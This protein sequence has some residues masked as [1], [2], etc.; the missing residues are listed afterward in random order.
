MRWEYNDFPMI[1]HTSWQYK[2][3]VPLE[4]K[5]GQMLAVG[6]AAGADGI[7]SLAR[8][9]KASYAGNVILF[10]RNTPDVAE[11]RKTAASVKTLIREVTG[12]SPLIAIDQEGGIVSRLKGGLTPLPGAMAQAAAYLGGGIQKSDIK[13]LGKICAEELRSLG[14]NW[15]LAPVADV[16][17]NP[18]N[19][20]IG[21]RSY[22]E[23]PK[24]VADLASSFAAGL[25]EGGVLATAKHFPGHGD[26]SVDSH[27]DIPLV[28]HG[29]ERLEAVEFVPFRRLVD[30][31]IPAV[32]TAHIRLP[33]VEPD[34]LPATLSSRVLQGLLRKKLG[35]EGIIC[36]DCMEMK[37]IADH[38][39]NAFVMAVKAG[40]D[41]LIISHT[42]EKQLY[43]AHSIYEAVK[44]SEIAESQIDASV[45][46]ILAAKEKIN[47]TSAFDA[48]KKTVAGPHAVALAKK[49]SRTSLSVLAQGSI[50]K[51]PSGS[52]L[53][54]VV[55]GNITN[56]EDSLHSVSIHA[57]LTRQNAPIFSCALPLN[58]EEEDIA[59]ALSCA[60][61]YLSASASAIQGAEAKPAL[62]L[63]L[64]APILH[65]GQM[66]LVQASVRFA[67]DRS[68]PLLVILTR[69]PYD[70]PSIAKEAAR[71]NLPAPTIVCSYEYSEASVAS[72]VAFLTGKLEAKGIC[73]VTVEG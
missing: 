33:S 47:Q 44:K 5:I 7:S 20:V 65:S 18:S 72:I 58:P 55:P 6:F 41:I 61:R 53:V 40:V 48:Y 10:T 31:G 50:T 70:A 42:A 15:D 19:P 30:E 12:V 36:S 51:P 3:H 49:I 60:E 26:T 62:I 69:N 45:E 17:S 25:N 57:E 54:D 13:A 59:A 63:A 71:A 46:R 38:F 34:M 14:I 66:K 4:W 27:L 28:P 24:L 64:H 29:I 8:V 1:E 11:T 52:V 21:V 39:P 2:K 67:Q 9:V 73:P 56:A 35:F 32:M 68:C 43:A 16:N 22:G 23:N 37:A